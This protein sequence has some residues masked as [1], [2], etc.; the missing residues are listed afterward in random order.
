M[1][2]ISKD[3]RLI[4]DKRI[5]DLVTSIKEC[6]KDNRAGVLNYSI[7]A[8]LKELYTLKYSEVNEAVGVLECAKQEYYRRVAAPYEDKKIKENGDVY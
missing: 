6:G 8:L 5:K 4:V 3:L 1:P 7:S 2:Y